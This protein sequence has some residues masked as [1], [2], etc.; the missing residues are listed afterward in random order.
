MAYPRSLADVRNDD[1]NERLYEELAFSHLNLQAVVTYS[2]GQGK[3][4]EGREEALEQG[5]EYSQMCAKCL[6]ETKAHSQPD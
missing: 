5:S 3:S 6:C 4:R 2:A 1:E